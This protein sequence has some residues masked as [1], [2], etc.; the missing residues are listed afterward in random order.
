MWEHT[1]GR[2]LM[3]QLLQLAVAQHNMSQR[4][5]EAIKVLLRMQE[6]DKDDHLVRYT[7]SACIFL[8]LSDRQ[9]V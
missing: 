1:E 9:S 5:K 6:L 2:V 8:C 3:R 4:T 7:L